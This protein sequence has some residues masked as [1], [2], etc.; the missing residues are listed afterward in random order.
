MQ[1][2]I[3]ALLRDENGISEAAYNALVEWL[4]E[5]TLFPNAIGRE[6]TDVL[7]IVKRADATDGRFYL[8]SD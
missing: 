1:K 8:P 5:L 2:L 3:E 6:A 4:E 7:V